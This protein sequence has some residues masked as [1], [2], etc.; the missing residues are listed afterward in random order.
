MHL[1]CTLEDLLTVDTRSFGD[2]PVGLGNV[3]Q[4]PYRNSLLGASA[5]C[6]GEVHNPIHVTSWRKDFNAQCFDVV[7]THIDSGCNDYAFKCHRGVDR[8]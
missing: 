8:Q 5:R 3:T 1:S 7:L 4:I 6:R 2:S